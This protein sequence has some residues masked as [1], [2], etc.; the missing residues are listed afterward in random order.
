MKNI[1]MLFALF[2]AAS[3]TEVRAAAARPAASFH[4]VSVNLSNV[5]R[6]GAGSLEIEVERWSTDEEFTK[7]RD[8][9]VEKGSD[10]LLSAM[11][12][13]RPRVGYIRN[14][15][16]GIGWNLYYARKEALPSGGYRVI[17][18]TDRPMTFWEAS[19]RPRSLDYD[20]LVA[21]ML[22]GKDGVGQGKLIPMARVSF[23]DK[24][25]ALEIEGFASEPVRLTRVTENH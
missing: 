4:A 2:A 23:D 6:Q 10:A 13:V 1:V 9:L 25:N 17:F 11:Q 15:A 5:G 18:A 8:A 19:N 22:I 24:K 3:A 20:F 21:E 7:L 12:K 16:G 14:S